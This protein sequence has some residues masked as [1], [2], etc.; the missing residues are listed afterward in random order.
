MNKRLERVASTLREAVQKVILRGLADPRA[1]GLITVTEVRITDDLKVAD[2]YISVFPED[3][4]E[5]TMH[6]I[7]HAATHLRRQAGDLMALHE[8]PEFNFKLDIRLK[9][10]AAVF[11]ALAKAREEE[12]RNA[13]SPDGTDAPT[14]VP[15]QVTKG[16]GPAT[17]HAADP[18]HGQPPSG[19]D[20]EARP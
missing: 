3:R 11:Q 10:Q 9:Q 20:A 15:D 17:P 19:P 8:L 1:R 5:L 7:R 6:A 13:P 18:A 14:S 16:W 4:Q 2:I 12:E